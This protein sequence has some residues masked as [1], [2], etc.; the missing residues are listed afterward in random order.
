[1]MKINVII[2]VRNPEW[3]LLKERMADSKNKDSMSRK[4]REM[5]NEDKIPRHPEE[6]D[7]TFT[8][9]V[10]SYKEI[11]DSDFPMSVNVSESDEF[12]SSSVHNVIFKNVA[13]VGF[14]GDKTESYVIV[15][16]ELIH[17]FIRDEK[18][19]KGKQYW[20][21]YLKENADY[22]RLAENVWLSRT[23]YKNIRKQV[24]RFAVERDPYMKSKNLV[25]LLQPDH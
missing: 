6:V 3:D 11:R 4:E 2:K 16:E 23:E 5:L 15:S 14:F 9:D 7:F 19:S 24:G 22:V 10:K 13:V 12:I 18:G 25:G 1:M 21:F 8:F 20:Y 17:Q